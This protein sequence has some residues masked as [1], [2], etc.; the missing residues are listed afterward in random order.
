VSAN[1]G[2]DLRALPKNHL[3]I[4]LEGAMR[5]ETLAELCERYALER[6]QDTRGKRFANFGGFNDLYWAATECIRTRDDLA[7]VVL[8]VAQDAASHGVW[9]MEPAF[10]TERYSTLREGNPF[11]LFETQKE[12]W[13]FML[14]AASAASKAT[15]VGIGYTSAIDRTRSLE[16]AMYRAQ[17]TAE[18]VN[19]GAHVIDMQAGGYIGRHAGIV[20]MGLH[21][22]EAG[23]PPE[24]FEAAFRAAIDGTGLLSTPHA[25]EIAPAPGQGPA[26][27]AGAIDALGADRIA[28]GVLAITEPELIERLAA[29][30]I[31]L[32]VCPTSNI[33]L[34][35]FPS[36]AE[37]PLPEFLDAGVACSLG[38]NDPLLFGPGLLEEYELCRAEMALNDHQLARLAKA[39]FQYSGAPAE[40][41]DAGVEAVDR[42]LA[43]PEA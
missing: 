19:S 12:G 3:H 6:P 15:G 30:Q 8:E 38:S 20:A 26:S 13:L 42:W 5:P 40:L 14:E 16:S 4:H 1:N 17:V 2:R 41:R 27:V 23:F 28:H 22:N 18:I 35:V 7:R 21:S 10:D 32:D 36:I 39:S 43:S 29:E 25:G 34:S 31:C 24:P 11:R 33:L 9:W 37:H